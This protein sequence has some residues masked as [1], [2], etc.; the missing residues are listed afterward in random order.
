MSRVEVSQNTGP[1]VATSIKNARKASEGEVFDTETYKL[2][3]YQVVTDEIR[4]NTNIAFK[5]LAT[6]DI[7]FGWQTIAQYNI[8]GAAVSNGPINEDGILYFDVWNYKYAKCI[9]QGAFTG[10][11]SFRVLEKHNA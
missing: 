9:L 11:E 3:S 8:K 2:H 1:P 7:S 6:N 10:Y 5:I 4:P